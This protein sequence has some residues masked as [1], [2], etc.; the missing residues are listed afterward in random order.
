[1]IECKKLPRKGGRRCLGSPQLILPEPRSFSQRGRFGKDE[2]G[3]SETTSEDEGGLWAYLQSEDLAASAA[4]SAASASKAAKTRPRAR[5][6]AHEDDWDVSGFQAE[7]PEP[8][9][10]FPFELDPRFQ[11]R[12]V[13]RVERSEHVMV[14]A[15]T[16]AGKTAWSSEDSEVVAEYA[17]AHALRL[18]MRTIYTS[19]IKAL[20]NQKFQEFTRRFEGLGSVGIVTGDV[21]VNPE[22][23]CVIMTTEILRSMLYRGDKGLNQ[24]KWVIFDEVHY[25]NDA[26]RG[27]VW[28]EVII[29]LPPEA[30][31]LQTA[32]EIIASPIS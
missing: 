26:D 12:A 15:H 17:V 13:R 14:A 23:S 2:D 21:T 6:W 32:A 30:R 1:M 10:H 24:V 18:G 25:V 16:S 27:V 31:M 9:L 28:E 3:S 29:L 11:K 4:A 20:S 5:E 8:A 7:V 19:P 22:A